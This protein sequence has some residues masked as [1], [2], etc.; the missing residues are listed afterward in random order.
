MLRTVQRFNKHF[1]F[2]LQSDF[3]VVRKQPALPLHLSAPSCPTRPLLPALDNA[4]KYTK[5]A[6]I[7]ATK[8]VETSVNAYQNTRH[9]DSD[10][11]HLHIC[12]LQKLIS[13]LANFR[14]EATV[15]YSRRFEALRIKII[16]LQASLKRR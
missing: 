1:R 16:T 9:N 10:F 8:F 11:S 5:L 15:G 12:R 14:G 7:H 4:S 13:H 6:H 3:V 2:H